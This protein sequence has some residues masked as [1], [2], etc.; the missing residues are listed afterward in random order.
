[1]AL[2]PRAYEPKWMKTRPGILKD[3]QDARALPDPDPPVVYELSL[4]YKTN[5]IY[6]TT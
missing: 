1:M 5:I 4:I 2:G 6:M 3:L